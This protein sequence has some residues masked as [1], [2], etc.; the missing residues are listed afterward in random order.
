MPLGILAHSMP[1]SAVRFWYPEVWAIIL[2]FCTIYFYLVGPF[3]E[4]HQLAPRAELGE[5]LYFVA[6][7]LVMLVSEGT[8]LHHVAEKYLF[9]MHMTQHVL[10]T[11]VMA[12]LFIQ[13]IPDWLISYFL[14]Y[15]WI[16]KTLTFLTRPIIALIAFNAVNAAWH[17]PLFYQAVLIHHWFHIVQHVVFVLT[18]LLM[19]WPIVSRS[20]E[21]PPLPYGAQTLYIFGLLMVQLPLFAPIIFADSH[22]YDFYAAAPDLWGLGAIS[23]QQL[24]GAVM[25]LGGMTVMIYFMGRA[26]FRWV[27]EETSPKYRAERYR[28]SHSA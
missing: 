4:R 15:G 21:L 5:T 14:R 25:E 9:S 12:P 23:D 19:W 3:R 27:R 18:A 17:L 13:G 7:M 6:A 10:L 8:P 11:M 20:S 1:G 2:A 22:F 28:S 26:F 16:R 24:A